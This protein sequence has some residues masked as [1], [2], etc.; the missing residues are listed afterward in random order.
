[1]LDSPSFSVGRHSQNQFPSSKR[2]RCGVP[3][4]RTRSNLQPYR[5]AS[6]LVRT[7]L[8]DFFHPP[9]FSSAS[10]VVAYFGLRHRLLQPWF[11]RTQLLQSYLAPPC[12]CTLS[13]AIAIRPWAFG[14]LQGIH[15][16]T[17]RRASPPVRRTP[18]GPSHGVQLPPAVTSAKDPVFIQGL[19]HPQ[20]L[21]PQGSSPLDAL[22]PF[23]PSRHF[24]RG[25][26]WDCYLQGLSP[27]AD[28]DPLS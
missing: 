3:L 20:P 2:C 19:P 9:T 23:T 22:I 16:K 13:N 17:G 25:R 14:V 12:S 1:M 11:S 28:P 4:Q 6:P 7:T 5:P 18:L 27:P 15:R 8:V 21:R 10:E 24:C 26:S